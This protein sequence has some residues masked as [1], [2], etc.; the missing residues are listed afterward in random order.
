MAVLVTG[1]AGYIGSHMVLALLDAGEEVVVVDNRTVV[2]G[3]DPLPE[4]LDGLVLSDDFAPFLT[5]P[6]YGYLD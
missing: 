4:I 2:A 1:G 6:A 5:I 3:V